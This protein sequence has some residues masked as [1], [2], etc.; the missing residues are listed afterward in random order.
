MSNCALKECLIGFSRSVRVV[1]CNGEKMY[2]LKFDDYMIGYSDLVGINNAL[3]E[4][5][6]EADVDIAL[7]RDY[8]ENKYISNEGLIWGI[9]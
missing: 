6:R 9:S 2:F 7:G 3:A 5:S 1:E 4:L 8:L